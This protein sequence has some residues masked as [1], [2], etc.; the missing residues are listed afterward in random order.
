MEPGRDSPASNVRHDPSCR[1]HTDFRD[2]QLPISHMLFL[3]FAVRLTSAMGHGPADFDVQPGCTFPSTLE[4][5][6]A[7]IVE[8]VMTPAITIRRMDS[9]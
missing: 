6:N 7:M 2:S 4:P 9:H 5:M 1:E 3:E 8:S